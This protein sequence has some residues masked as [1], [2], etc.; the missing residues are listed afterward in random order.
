MSC[1][2]LLE[3]GV[4]PTVT[5]VSDG[6]GDDRINFSVFRDDKIIQVYEQEEIIINFESLAMIL[7]AVGQSIRHALAIL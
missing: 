3:T 1:L 7:S 2:S 4:K 5:I 6:F